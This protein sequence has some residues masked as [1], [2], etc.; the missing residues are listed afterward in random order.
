MRGQLLGKHF[1]HRGKMPL[2]INVFN[3]D[4]KERLKLLCE[5]IQGR[6][7]GTGPLFSIQ[8]TNVKQTIDES[9]ENFSAVCE[10]IGQQLPGGWM[11]IHHAYLYGN[12]FSSLS[13]YYSKH[14]KN[15]LSKL[16][17]SMADDFMNQTEV[18]E[19]STIENNRN[20]IVKPNG[21]IKFTSK[22]KLEP[23]LSKPSSLKRLSKRITWYNEKKKN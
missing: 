16:N 7:A 14:T 22:K 2:G 20:V 9:M 12:N 15:D 11:N 3:K 18:G 13:I 6:M 21:Q 17:L 1:R 19:L 4:L 5:S 23:Q 10:A 8:F